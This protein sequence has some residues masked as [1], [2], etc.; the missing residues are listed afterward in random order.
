MKFLHLADIHLGCRRYGLDER[1]KDFARAW[2]DVIQNYALP[3]EV[4]FVLLVG[5]FFDRRNVE[6]QAMNHAIAGLRLLQTAGIPVIAIEGNHD[7]RDT[8]NDYSWLRSLAYWGYLKLLEPVHD[9]T[10]RITL[11][12]WSETECSGSYYDIAGARIFGSIWYGAGAT[13]ALSLLSDALLAARDPKLFNILMM[14]TDVEGQLDRPMITAL[15][16]AKLKELRERADYIALGHT[17]K[18][19]ILD[20]WAFNPGSLEACSIDEYQEKRGAFL[21]EVDAAKNINATLIRDYCQR[22]FQR[23][24]YDVSGTKDGEAVY[25]GVMDVVAREAR[26]HAPESEA[27]AP[28]IEMSL[29]GHLGFSN[30]LLPLKKMRDDIKT[31]TQALHI[32][33][34]NRSV[35]VEYA[36]A[37]GLEAQAPRHERE[38]HIIEGLVMQNNLFKTRAAEMA[39]LIVAAKKYALNDEGPDKIFDLIEQTLHAPASNSTNGDTALLALARN[40]AVNGAGTKPE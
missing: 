12:P 29:R 17:H 2:L 6:P 39:E 24:Q 10:G 40:A 38:R 11:M 37:A 14:H 4:D 7:Q 16:I 18:Q 30:S 8:G 34:Q 22:P 5:D 3:Q 9:E 21:V 15:P 35:P 32:I 31:Q 27:P 13:Q 28:I 19:F 25:V 33:L 23:L 36:V 26:P 20:N 1:T